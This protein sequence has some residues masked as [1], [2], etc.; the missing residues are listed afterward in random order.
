MKINTAEVIINSI[1][2]LMTKQ[3][4]YTQFGDPLSVVKFRESIVRDVKETEVLVRMLA[5]PVNPSDLNTIQGVSTSLP[6]LPT[7]PGDEGVG[8][9]VEIGKKVSKVN[10]GDRVIITKP[11][12]GTWRYYGIFDELDLFK[13]SPNIPLPEASMITAAPSTAYRLI[14]DFY[15][16]RHGETIVQNA[17]NS[18]VG[19]SVIQIARALGIN[20]FNIVATHCQFEAVKE[21]LNRLGAAGSVFTLEEAEQMTN[22]TTSLRQPI[23]G[24]N[25]LGGRYEDVLLRLLAKNGAM[26][27]YGSC[28][29]SVQCKRCWRPDLA[30]DRFDI[31]EWYKT[32]TC[33]EKSRMISNIAQLIAT[34][35]FKAPMYAPVEL[36]NY[37][38]ALRNTVQCEAYSTVNYIFDFS[39]P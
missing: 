20:T 19:Q 23:L 28:Y 17:A 36:K 6:E 7:I 14:K 35:K 34:G 1:R 26:V 3:L 13:I 4:V 31:V 37:V 32:A 8:N 29:N 38:A 30:Y 21:N 39:I 24:L 5:A 10:I 9:V 12:L 2:K 15:T 11:R 27:Y 25:C 16:V 18:S 33:L 22:F